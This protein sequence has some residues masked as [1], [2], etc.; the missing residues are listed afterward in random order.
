MYNL[1]FS[2][3]SEIDFVCFPNASEKRNFHEESRKTFYRE[4]GNP[5]LFSDGLA[6]YVHKCLLEA[7]ATKRPLFYDPPRSGNA[8]LDGEIKRF[9]TSLCA[10]I[11]PRS[12]PVQSLIELIDGVLNK[13]Y[14]SYL[15]K[16]RF[17]S[18]VRSINGTFTEPDPELN[19]I[20][21][22][23]ITDIGQIFNYRYYFFWSEEDPHDE[24]WSFEPISPLTDEVKEEFS[25]ILY[26]MLP[27]DIEEVN[28]LEV[29][30]SSSSSSADSLMTDGSQPVFIEKQNAKGNCF[31][32]DPLVA[33]IVY[34]QKS[35][36]DTRG[37]SVHNISQSNTIKLVEKQV[38]EVAKAI[39]HSAYIS[40]KDEFER[41]YQ[42]YKSKF[43]RHYCKDYKKDGLTKNRELLI[44]VLK[45][46]A[47]KYP[48]ISAFTDYQ[49][50]FSSWSFFYPNDKELRCPPRGIGLGMSSAITTIIGCV[51][52]QMCLTRLQARGDLYFSGAEGLVYHD[53]NTIGFFD[54]ESLQS[55]DEIDDVL[56]QDLGII[57]NKKKSFY[58]DEFVLCE[59]YSN[60]LNDK[61]SYQ[62]NLLYSPYAACNIVHGK[63]LLQ[64]IVRFQSD[65]DVLQFTSGYEEYFGYELHPGE[66]KKPYRLGGWLPAVYL[67]IDTSFL[68]YE[69]TPEDIGAL[70]A[71]TLHKLEKPLKKDILNS[72]DIY[73]GPVEALF[74]SNLDVG[75]S[76]ELYT[77][78]IP[79]SKVFGLFSGF[80]SEGSLFASYELLRKKRKKTFLEV[81]SIPCY[82]SPYSIY[83]MYCE[84]F[85]FIDFLPKLEWVQVVDL[86]DY[87][88][89]DVLHHL[90]YNVNRYLGYLAYKNPNNRRLSNVIPYPLPPS[91]SIT[92][93]SLTAAERDFSR[94]IPVG[95]GGTYSH[96]PT[97]VYAIDDYYD[98]SDTNWIYPERVVCAFKANF[99]LPVMPIN[100]FVIKEKKEVNIYRYSLFNQWI[101]GSPFKFI[102]KNLVKKISWKALCKPEYWTDYFYEV[103]LRSVLM[104]LKPRISSNPLLLPLPFP[105]E[106][107]IVFFAGDIFAEMRNFIEKGFEPLFNPISD[108]GSDGN[109]TDSDDGYTFW[110]SFQ[111][112]GR[113]SFSDTS[114][115]KSAYSHKQSVNGSKL[116]LNSSD[117]DSSQSYEDP[118]Q[119]MV[120][121]E[122]GSQTSEA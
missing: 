41:R 94:K 40:D 21:S 78:Q 70:S 2:K 27:E 104:E 116:S 108:F 54:D 103:G 34:V 107:E 122:V 66:F 35:P 109:N 119:Y 19:S 58:A 16:L 38:A 4:S 72:K 97:S 59:R 100:S 39:P 46:L 60:S 74:G 42:S 22:Y 44:L 49:N 98:F 84:F 23:Y 12:R 37:A 79:Y 47:R 24:N 36:G 91:I 61:K 55:Y 81:S 63:D 99:F 52:I 93:K 64:Q 75:S 56:C 114:S 25:N 48:D 65:F 69:H 8:R 115:F 87:R 6:K 30:L 57:K 105:D 1:D 106:E 83:Q 67:G 80:R 76:G 102:F 62:L 11:D 53:D 9:I 88:S 110:N 3:I 7:F 68:W 90:S 51:V 15:K 32:K 29:L 13:D 111:E 101:S 121:S 18:F 10:Y 28:P 117:D 95:I 120:Q 96:L 45:V 33:K 14:V 89:D 92:E 118:Y 112:T 85:P 31:S 17:K 82:K 113:Q 43:S 77:Y 71:C 20:E 26:S 73:H 86:N 50:L 5:I